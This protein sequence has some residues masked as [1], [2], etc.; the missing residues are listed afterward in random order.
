MRKLASIEELD[1]LLY[2]PW[3]AVLA[4]TRRDGTPLLSPMIYEWDGEAL[5]MPVLRGDWKERHIRENSSWIVV[6]IAEEAT[7]P[8]RLL[9]L[10]G[11]AVLEDDPLAP[12]SFASRPAIWA[13]PYPRT[14]F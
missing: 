8:G 13:S 10:A 5:L 9:E 14:T 1:D 3:L 7:Y 11:N 4:T 12:R 6:C 2:Q